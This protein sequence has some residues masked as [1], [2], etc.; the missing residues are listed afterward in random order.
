MSDIL[1]EQRGFTAC[2]TFNRPGERNALR[3]ATFEELSA[4]LAAC[5]AD[6]SV[7]ALL[8]S[9]AGLAFSAGI[10]LH[11]MADIVDSPLSGNLDQPGAAAYLDLM[12]QVTRQMIDLPKPLIAALNGPAVGVG[13]EIAVACDIRIA[14]TAAWFAFAEV[15]RGLFETNGVMYRLPRMVGL[16]RA[17][18]LLLT[19]E[20][21]PAEEA[22][23]A[24]LVTRVVPPAELETASL[25]TAQALGANAP[26]PMRLVKRL[27]N[28]TYDLDLEG[29]LRQ[30][31]DG[32]LACL[33]SADMREG[34]RAFAEKRDPHYKGH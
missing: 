34:V 26:I 27:L 33:R 24:G 6:E 18:H 32:M 15:Q 28:Q 29:M 10:D 23:A 25:Q 31:V 2:A 5:A 21:L 1:F 8:I 22:L 14:S 3:K 19:G 12:Q 16:G 7:R 30:E 20:R 13:A 17:A 4:W 9:G 11:E